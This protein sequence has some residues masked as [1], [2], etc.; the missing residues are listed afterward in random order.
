MNAGN[1]L[2]PLVT[3]LC[4][5]LAGGCV[6]F[7]VYLAWRQFGPRHHHRRHRSRLRRFQGRR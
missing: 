4:V 6:A 5:V 1:D 3:L 7:V 2:E